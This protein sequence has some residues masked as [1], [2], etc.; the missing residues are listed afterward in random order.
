MGICAVINVNGLWRQTGGNSDEQRLVPLSLAGVLTVVAVICAN[1][2]N[3]DFFPRPEDYLPL[4]T[5]LEFCAISVS[6]MVCGLG[7]NLRQQRGNSLSVV[8]AS[9]F[10]S[11]A[12]V[13]LVHTLS[14]MGMPSFVTPSGPEKAINFWLAGRILAASGLLCVAI[15]PVR[16]WSP[17][18]CGGIM[19]S[20]LAATFVICWVGLWHADWLPRTFIPGQGLTS[21][22][23]GTEYVLMVAYGA[24]ALLLLW[25]YRRGGTVG[26]VWLAAASW[27]L[28]LGESFFTLYASVT[29]LFNL[30]GHVYKAIAYLMIY[31]ALFVE[32]VK[33]P[34]RILALERAHLQTLLATIPD[35]V[36]LKDV[37]GVYLSCNPEF[38]RFFGAS[39]AQIVGKTD[40]DF[41]DTQLADF[42]RQKDRE[43]MAAGIPTTNDE[44]V[45]YASD[46]HRALLETTKTPM[47]SAAGQLIGV[48]GIARDITARVRTETTLKKANEDLE[49]FAY[50]ASH[51]LREP[52]R[53]IS[54]YI[55]MLERRYGETFDADGREFMGYVREG[56]RRMDRMVLDLL[57][58]S[59]VGGLG[60]GL[61][62]VPLAEVV[63][64]AIANLDVAIDDTKAKISVSSPLP[65]VMGARGELVRLVQN[66]IDN[67]LTYRSSGRP[68]AIAIGC[69][70][71]EDGWRCSV[72][73]N[74][75]GIAPEY[76]ERIF[77]I[78]QRLHTREKYD[79]TG[80]GLAICKKI[81]EHHGG[82]L[83]VESR[84]GV[85]STFFFTLPDAPGAE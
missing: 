28:G 67:A 61:A 23:I 21:A 45:T 85:G 34:Y 43:A 57:E 31:R 69:V 76:F 22:K 68:P 64:T 65:T 48:L 49:Q 77:G 8:L 29:D 72:S 13:D 78:F 15:L 63:G 82:R 5:I 36:W 59:R 18:T 73:D 40:Y 83:W 54:G 12:A 37:K 74:G 38:G 26:Q 52:L 9:A 50:V 46:G 51:D 39:E 56:A 75:I 7:W 19:T 2:P 16:R 42:F 14:Y 41:V 1:L 70:K 33:A 6:A 3:Q 20:T 53:M 11:V 81:I 79:G 4:H 25:R 55:S 60:D 44:W 24:A 10:L 66:L 17:S 62:P 32:G 47:F 27:T 35:L 30:V 84:Q 71:G 80:I 58:Y